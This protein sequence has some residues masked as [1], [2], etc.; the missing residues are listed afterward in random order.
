MVFLKVPKSD[1]RLE[2]TEILNAGTIFSDSHLCGQFG[3]FNRAFH[4]HHGTYDRTWD[5]SF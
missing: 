2:D 1:G 3:H 4:G 5:N